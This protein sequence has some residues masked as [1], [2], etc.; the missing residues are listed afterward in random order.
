MVGG[1]DTAV[2]EAIYLTKY[3]SRVHLLVRGEAL[4]ASKAM[5]ERATSHRNIE[6][7]YNTVIQD[8][9][10]DQGVPLAATL[11]LTWATVQ[12]GSK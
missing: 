8:A 3:G 4:R 2:E 7:H 5:A 1:G 12:L 10:A 11:P 6:V 9:Y